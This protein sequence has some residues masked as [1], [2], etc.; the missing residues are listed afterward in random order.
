MLILF[1]L[2]QLTALFLVNSIDLIQYD[3]EEVFIITETLVLVT[4]YMHSDNKLS[5]LHLPNVL[6]LA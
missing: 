2:I 3:N 4:I 1:A 6:G 5:T